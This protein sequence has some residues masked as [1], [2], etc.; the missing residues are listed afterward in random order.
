MRLRIRPLHL[1]SNTMLSHGTYGNLQNRLFA[2][3][4]E[5]KNRVLL[6]NG[7]VNSFDRSSQ[8]GDNYALG[9]YNQDYVIP[10]RAKLHKQSK[11]QTTAFA[12]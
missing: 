3:V 7:N 1:I 2:G 10:K 9:S 8:Y 5:Y 11:L 6:G 4:L 12:C